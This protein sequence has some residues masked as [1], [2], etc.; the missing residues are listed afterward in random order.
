MSVNTFLCAVD[1]CNTARK[2]SCLL[3]VNDARNDLHAT[4]IRGRALDDVF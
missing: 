4:S 2:S 3:S 1:V